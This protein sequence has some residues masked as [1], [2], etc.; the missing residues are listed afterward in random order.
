MLN[1]KKNIQGKYISQKSDEEIKRIQLFRLPFCFGATLLLTV[2]PLFIGQ[3][4]LNYLLKTKN[5]TAI[6]S[7]LILLYF[8]AVC[9]SLYCL[10]NSFIRYKLRK[11]IPAKNMPKLDHTK[12]T[13]SV[14]EWQTWL[15]I[16][17]TIAEIALTAYKFSVGGLIVSLLA[18]ASAVCAFMVKKISF[19]FHRDGLTLVT[20]ES[21]LESQ[22]LD[23][24]KDEPSLESTVL[25]KLKRDDAEV[26]D[27][28]DDRN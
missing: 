26:E 6:P 28:Y 22:L 10:V 5:L 4:A 23:T 1:E 21:S 13:W 9:F 3:S 12:H 11:E 17:F 18:I 16:L 19:E 2:P 27:F 8:V 14:I 24:L 20:L 7:A 15:I 25:P